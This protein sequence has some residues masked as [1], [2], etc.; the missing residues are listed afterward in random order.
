MQ[1][2]IELYHEDNGHV[3]HNVSTLCTCIHPQCWCKSDDST[4]DW[5]G[6]QGYISP[7]PED[8]GG[9]SNPTLDVYRYVSFYDPPNNID[10]YAILFFLENE[11]QEQQCVTGFSPPF[12]S[13]C[14]DFE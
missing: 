14:R 8:P 3:P 11:V 10:N 4:D 6:L 9:H 5:I 7:I 1:T 2:A 13:R 12:S